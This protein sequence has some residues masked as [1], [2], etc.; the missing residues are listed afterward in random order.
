MKISAGYSQNAFDKLSDEV[1]EKANIQICDVRESD[2]RNYF[3]CNFEVTNE[4]LKIYVENRAF[5]QFEVRAYCENGGDE[6]RLYERNV[7][8]VFEDV[9][10]FDGVDEKL[11]LNDYKKLLDDIGKLFLFSILSGA[12]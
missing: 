6:L 12:I 11:K 3:E 8:K 5:P 10:F 1:V 7:D 4:L 2:E 9:R